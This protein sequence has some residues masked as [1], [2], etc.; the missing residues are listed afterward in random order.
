MNQRNYSHRSRYYEIW[1]RSLWRAETIRTIKK[2]RCDTMRFYLQ[3]PLLIPRYCDIESN[4]TVE[5]T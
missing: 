3:T 1:N 2:T 5:K 4:Q